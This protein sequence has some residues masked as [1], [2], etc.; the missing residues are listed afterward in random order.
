MD[1]HNKNAA[2][3]TI[4]SF[5]TDSEP[6][7]LPTNHPYHPVELQLHDFGVMAETLEALGH[8]G[9]AA[10]VYTIMI[11]RYEK[12]D[13][14]PRTMSRTIR[15]KRGTCNVRLGEPWLPSSK[16]QLVKLRMVNRGSLGRLAEAKEDLDY[17][18]K[19]PLSSA[20]LEPLKKH[21]SRVQVLRGFL[22]FKNSRTRTQSTSPNF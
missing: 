6:L 18:S 2:Y 4:P 7:V 8:T 13:C 14:F 9:A 19:L 17:V 21:Q 3:P 20:S 12:L 11:N 15:I 10:D 1:A 5:L 22:T 16:E